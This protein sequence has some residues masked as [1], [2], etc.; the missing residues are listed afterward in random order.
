MSAKLA[1][2]AATYNA[3]KVQ[4]PDQFSW[5]AS[6]HCMAA[7]SF[8]HVAIDVVDLNLPFDSPCTPLCRKITLQ[9]YAASKSLEPAAQ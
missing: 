6:G 4:Q 2:S 1:L 9:Q 7:K 3:Y 5:L 8:K